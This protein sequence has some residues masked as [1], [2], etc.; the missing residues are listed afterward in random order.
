MPKPT[1]TSALQTRHA[2]VIV[3]LR[4]LADACGEVVGMTPAPGREMVRARQEQA[5]V[6]RRCANHIETDTGRNAAMGRV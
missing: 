1:S 4:E 3:E 6:Y 5:R 2:A